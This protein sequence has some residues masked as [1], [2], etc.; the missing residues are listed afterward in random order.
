V[1]VPHIVPS[2]HHSHMEH[3]VPHHVP[4]VPHVP[5]YIPNVHH[6]HLQPIV[7]TTD[8]TAI[9]ERNRELRKSLGLP[10]SDTI[11]HH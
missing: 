10:I 7:H 6:T 8:A 5:A 11:L 9:L 3:Y 4:Y 1:E 2:L